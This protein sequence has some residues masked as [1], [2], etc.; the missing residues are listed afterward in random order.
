MNAKGATETGTS[1]LPRHSSLIDASAIDQTVSIAR[2][3]R[4]IESRT[5]LKRLG[6][7]DSQCNVPGL[8]IPIHGVG[9][10]VVTYQY[11]PDLPRIR[12]GKPLKYETPA[13]TRMH[14]DVPPTALP[15]LADPNRPLFI[16]EGAR[17][18]DSAVSRG[19][20]C[21]ALL[22]VWNWRGTN[23]LGGKLALADWDSVALNDRATYICF[24]S[25]VMEKEGVHLALVRLKGLLETRGARVRVI[26]LP[27]GDGGVKVGLDDYFASHVTVDSLL[28]LASDQVRTVANDA[29]H[30]SWQPY[31]ATEHGLVWNRSTTNGPI[32]TPLSNFTARI[33]ADVQEDDGAETRR[34]LRIEARL[35][36]RPQGILLPAE[37][38][39]GMNWTIEYLG[40]AAIVY[41]GFGIKDHARAAIQSLSTDIRHERVFAHLGWR[42]IDGEWVYL[43]AGGGIGPAGGVES[44]NV[45]L[46]PALRE[47]SLPAPPEGPALAE[48]IQAS[49]RVLEVA[50][51]QVTVPL[52]ASIFR[53]VLGTSDFTVQLTGPT[54]VGKTELAALV[55]QH[56]GA[57]M[58]ARHL[59]A[60]WSSTSNAVEGLAFAAKDA[61]LTVD[62]F[63]PVGSGM[64]I[65]RQNR[66]ADRLI[67]AQGNNAGRQRMR[68]D[69]TLRPPK[70][71]RGLLI[72]TGEDIPSGHSLRARMITVHVGP[73]DVNFQRLTK[74]QSEARAGLFSAA[75]AGF[76]RWLAP[77]YGDYLTNA[78][79]AQE[80]SR[81]KNSRVGRH[82]RT[83]ST[84]GELL[85]GLRAFRQYAIDTG[86]ISEIQAEQYRR[87]WDTALESIAL[88]QHSLQ[89]S[90]EPATRFVELLRASIAH[91]DSHIAAIDGAEPL[92]PAAW[93]WRSFIIGTG[94]FLRSEWRAQGKSVGWVDEVN[95]Y[96]EPDAAYAAVQSFTRS[97]GE[98]FTVSANTLRRRLRENGLLSSVDLARETLVIRRTIEGRQ[99]NVLHLRMESLI[100]LPNL[101]KPDIGQSEQ[102]EYAPRK[103]G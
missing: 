38:F 71:P 96:L 91:G 65:Q 30:A 95:L 26:Y 12:D 99:Q 76:I 59:P 77:S 50:P 48:S 16:T 85:L 97:I 86:A 18:A 75:L 20:C 82:L 1:L 47:Y 67:R 57:A 14:L 98:T 33:V 100:T 72:S 103:T 101:D 73:S 9:G 39:A 68:P 4:S 74:C 42:E 7:A 93:G 79:T 41:P 32:D 31:R 69:G 8:L 55:Q 27:C 45:S 36:G 13:K 64:D 94:E 54:G 22:G 78:H 51:P 11:R 66:D 2:G 35:C 29:D 49:L 43:H 17:K 90:G 60:S 10:E 46:P 88:E 62:D 15:W 23:E 25:D 84:L 61:V 21:V 44:V 34:S 58:D 63:S 24:D 6:F 28:W 3:Y 52:F 89:Q 102:H 87:D 56:Y 80:Q 70:P 40:A 53:A 19:L 5:A 83:S 37:R 81:N 92:N